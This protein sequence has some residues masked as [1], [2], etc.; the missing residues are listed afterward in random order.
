VHEDGSDTGLA[1]RKD[2]TS[3]WGQGQ[4]HTWGQ[5]G[6]QERGHDEV[7]LGENDVHSLADERVHDDKHEH[8]EK[9]RHFRR[10]IG[11]KPSNLTW[12]LI[13]ELEN[14]SGAQ[15]SKEN[16]GDKNFWASNVNHLEY[17]NKILLIRKSVAEFA[18]VGIRPEFENAV[19]GS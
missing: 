10:V 13:W 8:M 9:N 2:P 4:K 1:A 19:C 11:V 16:S 7:S 15:E 12:C 17:S 14:K 18:K 6:K 3:A 5:Q